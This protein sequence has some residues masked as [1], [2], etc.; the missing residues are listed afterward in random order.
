ML[1]NKQNAKRT[2]RLPANYILDNRCKRT[3]MYYVITKGGRGTEVGK[4]WITFSTSKSLSEANKLPIHGKCCFS[5][6]QL[7]KTISFYPIKD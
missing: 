4:F 2:L 5:V 6:L 3:S 1:K 7:F